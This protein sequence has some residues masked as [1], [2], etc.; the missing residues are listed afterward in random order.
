MHG[1]FVLL[2][3]LVPCG[4]RPGTGLAEPAERPRRERSDRSG[5]GAVRRVTAQQAPAA[6]QADRLRAAG[7]TE[8]DR[9]CRRVSV[10]GAGMPCGGVGWLTELRNATACRRVERERRLQAARR[11]SDLGREEPAYAAR[12][13]RNMDAFICSNRDSGHTTELLHACI[14]TCGRNS[15]R[16]SATNGTSG[17]TSSVGGSLGRAVR[18]GRIGCGIAGGALCRGWMTSTGCRSM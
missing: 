11:T 17:S 15:V 18:L 13:S 7:A 6:A 2:V 1:W 10:A 12:I 8:L 9:P 5:L 4:A 14:C 16:I 3:L